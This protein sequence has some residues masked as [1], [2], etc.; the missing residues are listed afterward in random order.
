MEFIY[1]EGNFWAS[2][3]YILRP[4]RDKVQKNAPLGA[5]CRVSNH[6]SKYKTRGLARGNQTILLVKGKYLAQKKVNVKK[7]PKRLYN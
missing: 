5:S 4:N 3:Y 6:H 1:D 2:E 7:T